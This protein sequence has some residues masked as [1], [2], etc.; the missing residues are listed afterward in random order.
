MK[1]YAID[2]GLYKITTLDNVPAILGTPEI[3]DFIHVQDSTNGKTIYINKSAIVTVKEVATTS[4][5]NGATVNIIGDVLAGFGLGKKQE[6]IILEDV[7]TEEGS[8]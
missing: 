1:L 4:D 3:G 6:T 2:V 8:E 7:Q 5:M